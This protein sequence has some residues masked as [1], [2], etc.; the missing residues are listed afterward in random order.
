[1]RLF[2]RRLSTNGTKTPAGYSLGARARSPPPP[3]HWLTTTT[4]DGTKVTVARPGRQKPAQPVMRHGMGAGNILATWEHDVLPMEE[5]PVA[6][7]RRPKTVSFVGAPMS[8]GQPLAGTDYGPQLL[9][10]SGV[11]R[12]LSK[13]GW[14]V[15]DTGDVPVLPPSEAEHRADE[16]YMRE[17]SANSRNASA[18]GRMLSSLAQRTEKAASDGDFVLTVGG[19]HSVALGTLFGV[20]KARPDTGVLWVDAHADLHTPLSSESGNMHGMPVGILMADD[21]VRCKIPG[22]E[23]LRGG[24]RLRP[25][26]IVYIGCRD[27]DL[28][29]RKQIRAQNIKC[30][31]MFEVDKYGVG[32]VVEQAL[33]HLGPTCPLHLSYDIDAVDPEHAPSTGTV[34]RGGFNFREA[35]YIAEAIAESTRLC[36]MDLVEIKCVHF[37]LCVLCFWG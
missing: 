9:R 7:L 5:E 8:W 28:A 16:A 26:Q 10:E 4:T 23:W 30:F 34:V 29:E 6:L 2:T 25:S 15:N 3:P 32:S 24:P 12:A 37:A 14:R 35:H 33:K 36:S 27:L 13:V 17:H 20:L 19:D 1:M 18:V 31:T 11:V 22:F 21:S